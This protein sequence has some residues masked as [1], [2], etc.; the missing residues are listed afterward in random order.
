MMMAWCQVGSFLYLYRRYDKPKIPIGRAR[1]AG[2]FQWVLK[3]NWAATFRRVKNREFKN[4][5]N[6]NNEE[7]WIDENCIYWIC[8]GLF[9]LCLDLF[10][11]AD[12]RKNKK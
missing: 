2:G 7:M 4:N 1:G 5:N 3:T 6:N 8:T 9:L 11:L 10:H 12:Q